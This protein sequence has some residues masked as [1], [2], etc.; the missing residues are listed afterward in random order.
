[1]SRTPYNPAVSEFLSNYTAGATEHMDWHD[2]GIKLVAAAYVTQDLPPPDYVTSVRTLVFHGDEILLMRNRD[3][4]H[5]LAGGRIEPGESPLDA[6]HREISEEAGIT[7]T[8]VL[9]LGF[10]HLQH[11][12]P[13]PVRYAY[14]YP[15]FFWLLFMSEYH[16]ESLMPPEPD[17]YE[18][19]AAFVP[20]ATLD[21]LG[22]RPLEQVF[23]AAAMEERE[24]TRGQGNAP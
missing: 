18:V 1:M 5:L 2:V 9:R 11:R 13:R 16:G 12:T 6:L 21:G 4:A 7:I 23:L 17:E 20:L 3:R 15:D 19:S 10:V 14:P 22:F 8:D 24:R